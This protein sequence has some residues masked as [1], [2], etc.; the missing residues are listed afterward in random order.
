VEYHPDVWYHWVRPRSSWHRN[1]IS[2]VDCVQVESGQAEP[3][4]L[5]VRERG[6]EDVKD[7][8][9]ICYT[10]LSVLARIRLS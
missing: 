8:V 6:R 2:V 3:A 10:R 1:K 4:Q 5:R 7:L 9:G